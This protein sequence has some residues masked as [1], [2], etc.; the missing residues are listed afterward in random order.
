M[1]SPWKGFEFGEGRGLKVLIKVVLYRLLKVLVPYR[2]AL[3]ALG[4]YN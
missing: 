1:G 3:P 2:S 4:K